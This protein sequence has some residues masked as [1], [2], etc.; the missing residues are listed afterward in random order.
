MANPSRPRV[1][2]HIDL[3]AFYTQVEMKLNP[4]LRGKPV[5][6]VQYNPLDRDALKFAL[7]PE[8][9]RISPNSN[10]G[11][12]AVSY[13]ARSRGVKRNMPGREA[14]KICPEL[15]L[16]QVPT[17]FGKADLTIYREAG[18]QV[19]SI[20]GDDPFITKCATPEC[21]FVSNEKCS[22]NSAV[23]YMPSV[24]N[25]DNISHSSVPMITSTVNPSVVN[26]MTNSCILE[27]ASIDEAYLDVTALARKLL[28]NWNVRQR[29][30]LS[31][32]HS[33]SDFKPSDDSLDSFLDRVEEREGRR[34]TFNQFESSDRILRSTVCLDPIEGFYGTHII[35]AEALFLEHGVENSEPDFSTSCIEH[36]HQNW[37]GIPELANTLK[38]APGISISTC[39][40]DAEMEKSVRHLMKRERDEGLMNTASAATKMY[41]QTKRPRFHSNSG[42]ATETA[43]KLAKEAEEKSP[44]L[45]K[46]AEAAARWWHRPSA[47]WEPHEDLLAAAAVVVQAL[48]GRVRRELEFTC[49]AGIAHYKVLAKLCSGLNKPDQQTVIPAAAV[50]A[51]LDPLPIPK[52]RSLGGKLGRRLMDQFQIQTIGEL[53]RLSEAQLARAVTGGA[54]AATQ[55]LLLARGIDAFAVESRSTTKSISCGKTFRG[56]AALTQLPPIFAWLGQ[57]AQE[58][59]ARVEQEKAE[60]RRQPLN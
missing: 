3:D 24:E 59:L 46:A 17:A 45:V 22:S 15:I 53:A 8:H 38:D 14:R 20:L 57:L 13:E 1:I 41:D 21:T 9:N 7:R 49:S 40:V 42:S 52:L 18:A 25:R 19:A 27:R 44:I 12:I 37:L 10:G 47:L 5:A 4:S 48:R 56:V 58:V 43:P 6:V 35:G 36:R 32:R 23:P 34:V 55:I 39:E 2:A 33:E 50:P 11:I 26:S 51:F 16:V 30:P 29:L 54:A 28:D 31:V 60:H